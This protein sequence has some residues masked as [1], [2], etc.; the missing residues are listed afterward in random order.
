MMTAPASSAI[1]S[2]AVAKPRGLWLAREM[3]FPLDTGDHIYTAFLAKSLAEAGVDLTFVGFAAPGGAR[4][5]LDWPIRWQH[6][7]GAKSG[8]LRGLL[9]TMPVVAATHATPA[10][11]AE[12]RRLAAEPWDF[13]VVDQYGMGWTLPLIHAAPGKP[14][15]VH[16]S[17]D[18]ETSVTRSIYQGFEGS[19]LKRFAYWQNHVKTGRM[20]KLIARNVD[21]LTTITEHD[22]TLFEA[23]SPGVR[24]VTLTPGYAGAPAEDRS[25]S[26]STPRHVLMVGSYHWIAKQENVRRFALAADEAFTANNIELHIV[27]SMPETLAQELRGRCKSVRLHGFAESLTPHF[28][29]SRMAVVPEEIGGGFKLKFL[30]FVFNRVPVATLTKAAE[31]VPKDVVDAMLCAD[32]LEGLVATIVDN[33]DRLDKLDR[34]QRR[35][36]DVAKTAFDWPRRGTTM[37]GAMVES[38]SAAA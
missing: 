15:L 38:R 29:G 18:H 33:I 23:Q 26:A 30:D 4:P 16:M 17:H 11:R 19:A 34:L 2:E 25:L 9:S 27:G 5:P 32:D 12:V 20:E 36:H 3:P 10:Y 21:L 1:E 8:R 7:E 6:V 37:L 31:G 13:I 14:V 24:T 35:A 22:A 28:V